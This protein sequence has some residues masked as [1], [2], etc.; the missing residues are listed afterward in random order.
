MIR[1]II[2]R[3]RHREPIRFWTIESINAPKERITKNTW[4]SGRIHLLKIVLGYLKIVWIFMILLKSLGLLDVDISPYLP[5]V[6]D[7]R[8]SLTL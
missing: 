4:F 8:A 7:A 1:L 2:L 6:S 5:Q 3:R